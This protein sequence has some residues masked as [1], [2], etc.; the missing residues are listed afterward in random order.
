MHTRHS[1]PAFSRRTALTLT[2]ALG[3]LGVAGCTPNDALHYTE[4]ENLTLDGKVVALRFCPNR[5]SHIDLPFTKSRGFLTLLGSPTSAQSI[6]LEQQDNSL[7]AWNR[8]LLFVSDEAN[9]YRISD[10]VT[11]RKNVGGGDMCSGLVD[12]GENR[13]LTAYNVGS[14]ESE[15]ADEDYI[16]SFSHSSPTAIENQ[17]E[18][19]FIPFQTEFAG[20]SYGLLVKTLRETGALEY[21]LVQTYPKVSDKVKSTYRPN[22]GES[23]E[24]I[25]SDGRHFYARCTWPTTT[26]RAES[27]YILSSTLVR[28][29]PHATAAGEQSFTVDKIDQTDTLGNPIVIRSEYP[30]VACQ[31]GSIRDGLMHW[32]DMNG[33]VWRTHLDTGLTEKAFTL[34]AWV[35][36]KSFTCA[37][38]DERGLFLARQDKFYR[39]GTL[40]IE[41]YDFATGRKTVVLSTDLLK[42][43]VGDDILLR[44]FAVNPEWSA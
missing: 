12:L 4:P 13:F 40:D 38:F 20:K 2:V 15:N 23:L 8:D 16:M 5:L 3:G 14:R 28:F 36:N 29:T 33:D 17:P 18:F 9:E 43:R 26:G 11:Q 27:N 32:F 22:E 44:D 37:K 35:A 7:I 21:S 30:A 34:D 24:G 25:V 6:T 19:G 1:T 41:H 10:K 42:G 31:P 39:S